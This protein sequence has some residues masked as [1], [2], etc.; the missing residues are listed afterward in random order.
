MIGGSIEFLLLTGLG[1][2]VT[3]L[4]GH[5]EVPI[6]FSGVYLGVVGDD[7]VLSLSADVVRAAQL[8]RELQESEAGLRESEARMSLAVDAGELGLWVWDLG[9]MKSGQRYVAHTVGLHVVG[10]PERRGCAATVAPG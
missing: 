3:V 9:G 8:V 4:W 10:A 7:G 6:V 1:L 5:G 2:A